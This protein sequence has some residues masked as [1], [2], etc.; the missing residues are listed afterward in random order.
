MTR[1]LLRLQ[2]WLALL[3]FAV[4]LLPTTS[5][6]ASGD[7][8]ALTIV[9]ENPQ[10][11]TV[12]Q[13]VQL[14]VMADI[15]GLTSK[16]DVTETVT[17]TTSDA[18]IVTVT[19]GKAKALKSGKATLTASQKGA[20]AQLHIQV[21]DKI[22]KIEASPKSYRFAKGGV[23]TLPKVT[24][25]RGN[26]SQEDVTNSVKWNMSASNAVLEN[27]SF[28]GVT[29]GR[30]T[31]EGTY[32][33]K[34]VKIPIAIE[35]EIVRIEVTPTETILNIKQ[36]KPLKVTGYYSTGKTV[37]LSK[38][39]T[40][41]SS[42]SSVAVVK[43]GS[44]KALAKGETR[45][46]S[47]WQGFTA[48]SD[49]IVEEPIKTIVASPKSYKFTKG[50][51]Q[52]LPK[53]TITRTSGSQENVTSSIKWTLSGSNAVLEN[54]SIR[55]VTPGRVTLVGKYGDKTVRVPIAIEDEIVRMEVT[56]AVTNL[57]IKKSKPLKVTGYY[58]SGKTV[59]LSKQV[60]WV[61]SNPSVAT[62]KNGSV[63]TLAQGEATLTGTYQ[64]MKVVTEVRVVPLLKKLVAGN[65]KVTLAPGNSTNVSIFAL[66]DT[67]Q[68]NVVTSNVEW[69][70]SKPNIVTVNNG[71]ITAVSKGKASVKA[72]WNKKTITINITVN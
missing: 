67:G 56:P 68:K 37:D 20:T 26:G 8:T 7:I 16:H 39:M 12:S 48:Q 4:V 54:G 11:L 40:W 17:W 10:K 18:S 36:S 51:T 2:G 31:L 53:V 69:T 1:A 66:Y 70:S 6:A 58:S 9:N 63:K 50:K 35:D 55:G 43:D 3:L 62:V 25:T 22:N 5:N 27:G 28:R 24:I 38:N 15:E 65:S 30:V 19:K 61:S 46:T 34:T 14:K 72:K 13:T 32:G 23:Q 21:E 33:G 42:N 49:V 52:S 45:L 60:N 47:A 29:P 44:I 64:N 71:R 57:N 59:N 41:K